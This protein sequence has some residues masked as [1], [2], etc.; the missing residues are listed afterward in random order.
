M[1]YCIELWAITL[2]EEKSDQHPS[3]EAQV[4]N[5]KISRN[6]SGG[7]P[8]HFTAG[9]TGCKKLYFTLKMYLSRVTQLLVNVSLETEIYPGCCV[10]LEQTLF[11]N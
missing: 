8:C 1:K 4:E 9:N 5:M 3:L 6:V 2:Q 11:K 7:F 10:L